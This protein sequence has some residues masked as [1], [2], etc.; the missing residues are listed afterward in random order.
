MSV[1]RSERYESTYLVVER[2]SDL[3]EKI[4]DMCVKMPK[5]YKDYISMELVDLARAVR[6]N[7]VQGNTVR[8]TKTTPY[9]D[10]IFRHQK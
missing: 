5:R 1:V 7:I 6:S 9:C 10:F 2:A 3:Y 8:L 4:I